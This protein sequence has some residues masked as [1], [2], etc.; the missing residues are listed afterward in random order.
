MLDVL[1]S[2]TRQP[3]LLRD[4]KLTNVH[5]EH[6]KPIILSSRSKKK[7]SPDEVYVELNRDVRGRL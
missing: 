5:F 6:E 7:T 2:R 3:R 1:R 4:R